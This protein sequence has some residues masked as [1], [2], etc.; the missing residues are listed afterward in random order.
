MMVYLL[1]VIACS[2]IF[3]G[4]YHLFL[5][6]EKTLVFNRFYLLGGLLASYLIPF[7]TITKMVDAPTRSAYAEYMSVGV[8]N[9]IITGISFQDYLTYLAYFTLVV[10]STLLLIR[11]IKNLVVIWRKTNSSKQFVFNGANVALSKSV[12]APYSFLNT[13]FL[14]E[15]E[16]EQGKIEPEV[17][18]HELAHVRQKHSYD[19][20]LVEILQI[21]CWFNP[22]LYLYK[23]AI[24]MNHELLA[25]ST[26]V[27]EFGNV[28]NYQCIL[29]QRATSHYYA[30]E[31]SSSFNYFT[32]KKRLIMLQK[33]FSK[34]RVLIASLA[35][36]PTLALALFAGCNQTEK[37]KDVSVSNEKNSSVAIQ[38]DSSNNASTNAPIDSVTLLPPPKVEVVKM[39]PPPPAEPRKKLPP[40]T[41]VVEKFGPGATKAELEEYESIV[42]KIK[43]GE[44]RY[45]GRLSDNEYTAM[46]GFYDKMSREQRRLSSKLPPPPPSIVVEKFGVGATSA[47]MEEYEAIIKKG[48]TEKNGVVVYSIGA[49]QK[50]T[51]YKIYTKMTKEQ[52]KSSSKLP[53]PPPPAEPMKTKE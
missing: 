1:K 22:I 40:P 5:S 21:F 23:N 27:K 18:T 7:I 43:V 36:V 12:T 13:I 9:P 49:D 50:A 17:L 3:Y 2:A 8:I 52:R 38:R 47:E 48:E 24:K 31:L 10:V 30:L 35:V 51:I 19:I 42:G 53:P 39:P 33:P 28:H 6:K 37:Q 32:T 34:K 26:V 25:D 29:L 11:F 45:R 46:I 15:E 4:L 14:C 41:I 44:N 20:L 16:Y